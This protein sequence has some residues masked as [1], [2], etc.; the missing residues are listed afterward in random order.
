M[1]QN[2]E[3]QCG[4]TPADMSLLE[5]FGC[6]G[7]CCKGRT[8]VTADEKSRIVEHSGSDHLFN[9]HGD[10]Y[11]LERGECPYLSEGLCSVQDV[12]PFVCMIFPYV[13]VVI[14]DS[15]WLYLVSEC[16]Y[17]SRISKSF[18]EKAIRLTRQFFK[19]LSLDEYSRYWNEN[20]IGDFNEERIIAKIKV[21]DG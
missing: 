10:I 17:A 14:D 6:K 2:L 8:M 1:D 18:T 9:W 7:K 19:H 4:I 20:K 5:E 21:I 13:P 16:E 11:F 12:K 15:L 3:W